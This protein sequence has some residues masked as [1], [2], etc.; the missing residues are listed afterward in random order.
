MTATR[1]DATTTP[2]DPGPPDPTG[3]GE[4]AAAF[5]AA[6]RRHAAGVAVVTAD[7][8]RGPAGFTA[9][10]V[11]SLSLDPPLLSFGVAGTASAWPA[12]CDTRWVVVNMLAADQSPLAT[13]F[14]TGG[15]D[16]FAHPTRWGRLASGEPALHD[17]SVWMR[18]RLWQR[19]PVG[20]HFLVVA[21]VVRAV[22]RRDAPPLIYHDGGYRTLGPVPP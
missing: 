7:A 20:D 6:F 18:C 3:S 5:R 2:L 11:V 22:V 14:A 13:T 17:A 21:L 15:V 10:S 9:S 16:R 4:S 1:P 8:G 19:I 12:I